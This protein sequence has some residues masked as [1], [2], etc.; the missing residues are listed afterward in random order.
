MEKPT[1]RALGG[2]ARASSLTPEKRK[3]I[4]KIA[5]EAKREL[6]AL[7]CATHGSLDHP[8]TI[9]EIE[10]PCYVLDRSEERRVGKE[11]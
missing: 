11:C 10:I 1:G 3:A 8:L 2:L 4:A 5:A 9:G 7:P 6:A